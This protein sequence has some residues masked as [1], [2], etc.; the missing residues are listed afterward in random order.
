MNHTFAGGVLITPE[1]R[2]AAIALAKRTTQKNASRRYGVSA[3]AIGNW[4][5]AAGIKARKACCPTH[6]EAEAFGADYIIP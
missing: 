6:A 3:V 2:S 1:L 4:M 5:K